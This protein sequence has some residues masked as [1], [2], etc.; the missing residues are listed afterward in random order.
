MDIKSG[1]KDL[2]VYFISCLLSKRLVSLLCHA[3][4]F[5][6]W[7]KK[8]IHIT[9]VHFYQPIPDTRTLEESYWSSK[10]KLIG[11]EMNDEGQKRILTQF[12]ANYK[13]EYQNFSLSK[14]SAANEFYID[15]GT[16]ESVDAEV[17][18]CMI[19]H[20]KPKKIIEIG[21]GNST[22][23]S[24]HASII[25]KSDTG[26]DAQFIAIE[27]Y[28]SDN[29][30]NGIP[31]LTQLIDKRIEQIDFGLFSELEE[32]DLLFIDSSHVLKVGSDV[33]KIYLDILPRLKKGVL[34]HIHDIFLPAEYP[35]EVIMNCLRFWTEQYL[36]QAFLAFNE[37]YNVLWASSYMHLNYPNLLEKAF[38]SYSR[39]S[40]W[41]GSFW[42]QKAK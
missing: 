14:P 32:N 21:S 8:G 1:I 12:S 20:F 41:P 30:K 37:S 42:I 18:Y 22:Y 38:P 24:A 11:I 26:A 31:G 2:L 15:N 19:R 6:I 28:P 23:L 17:L 10:S 34:I 25:N 7:E 40:R 13:K 29:L 9:P 35:K 4:Y 5:R 16:F 3:P 33:Q 36:L 39:E 27:P